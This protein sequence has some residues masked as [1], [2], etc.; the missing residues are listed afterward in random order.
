MQNLETLTETLCQYVWDNFH[1]V[2]DTE[3][4]QRLLCNLENAS[5]SADNENRGFAIGYIKTAMIDVFGEG[6]S[7]Y[8][9]FLKVFSPRDLAWQREFDTNPR[10]ESLD[11]LNGMTQIEATEIMDR[12]N[13]F[14]V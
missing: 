7:E 6:S 5:I 14:S 2:H 9:E 8:L 4:M 1:D 10:F 3:R 13:S 11:S 12:V